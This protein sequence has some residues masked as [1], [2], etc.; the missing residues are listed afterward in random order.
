MTHPLAS[1]LAEGLDKIGLA[2]DETV[3][4]QMLAYLDLLAKWNRS[5]NLT[6][7]RK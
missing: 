4:A 6:A 2:T 5:Y 3:Q 1:G 7:V